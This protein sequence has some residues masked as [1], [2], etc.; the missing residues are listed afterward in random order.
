MT[1]SSSN[2]VLLDSGSGE[3]RQSLSSHQRAT[4]LICCVGSFMVLLDVS[5]VILP[6]VHSAR[7]ACLVLRA[8]V[9]RRCLHARFRC[10]ALSQGCWPI[11]TSPS[12]LRGRDGD[13]HARVVALWLLGLRRHARGGS[14]AARSWRRALAR[15]AWR[16]LQLH[17]RTRVSAC[18]RSR[19][20]RRSADRA[21][22][23]AHRWWGTGGGCGLAVG[24]LHQRPRCAA[25]LLF[26]V[27]RLSESSDP[28]LGASM[29]PAR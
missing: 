25:C 18:G 4:L 26:G 1:V 27:Q 7:S 17:F 10:V 15:R 6:P 24:L 2:S 13:L 12:V 16:F 8:A 19:S 29:F 28:T 3:G 20:G 21:R 11:D 14:R 22:H 9:G 23:W 5:I